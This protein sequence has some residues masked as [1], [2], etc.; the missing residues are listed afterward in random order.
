MHWPGRSTIVAGVAAVL[1]VIVALS[2]YQGLRPGQVR[3]LQPGW[4]FDMSDRRQVAGYAD[5]VIIGMVEGHQSTPP[6]I[7][8]GG[9]TYF[10]W[11]QQILKGDPGTG[12]IPLR[13]LGV[14]LVGKDI[15]LIEGVEQ[16]VAGRT[17]AFAFTDDRGRYLLL[18]GP[19]CPEPASTPT[20]RSAAI[21]AWQDAIRNQHWPDNLP[22]E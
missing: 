21:A 3:Y 13:Q 4:A 5:H 10:V 22:P 9:T 2:A 19:H 6:S 7:D 17:Y 20:E 1:A 14:Q 12:L 18:S 11:V 8:P 16:V 15:T